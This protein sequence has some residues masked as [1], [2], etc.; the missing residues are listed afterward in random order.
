LNP[1][2]SELDRFKSEWDAMWNDENLDRRR[3]QKEFLIAWKARICRADEAPL[4][5]ALSEKGFAGE[6]VWDL[7][8]TRA[9]YPELIPVL[10]DHARIEYLPPIREGIF[11]ALT[12]RESGADV[13]AVLIHQ[14][15]QGADRTEK[16]TRWALANAISYIAKGAKGIELLSQLLDDEEYSNDPFVRRLKKSERGR[17]ILSERMQESVQ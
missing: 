1:L 4:V 8:N 7:V 11:R 14:W 5:G 13:L 17:Q 15:N 12:V 10:R 16:L 9:A 2:R 6:S 3:A